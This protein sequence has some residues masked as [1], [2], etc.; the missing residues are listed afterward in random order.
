MLP[1]NS[2]I[3][4]LTKFQT[5]H[6]CLDLWVSYTNLQLHHHIVKAVVAT[7][8]HKAT[9]MVFTWRMED[10]GVSGYAM[11]EAVCITMKFIFAQPPLQS[12]QLTLLPSPH[13]AVWLPCW[14]IGS[15]TNTWSARVHEC[16]M[17]LC[18]WASVCM[19][20]TAALAAWLRPHPKPFS[21][22]WM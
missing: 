19:C 14:F 22:Q 21:T 16:L 15:S 7:A 9:H 2:L 13:P 5:L 1:A 17:C 10:K 20:E 8:S 6:M 3:D 12:L 18:V 4:Q 11:G